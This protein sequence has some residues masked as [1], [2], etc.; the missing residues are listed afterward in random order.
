MKNS[1]LLK[2]RCSELLQFM[3][4]TC[5]PICNDHRNLLTTFLRSQLILSFDVTKQSCV[6]SR[7]VKLLILPN[8]SLRHLYIQRCVHILEQT[9]LFGC[10]LKIKFRFFNDIL[11]LCIV[12]EAWGYPLRLRILLCHVLSRDQV[13]IVAKS[14]E[15]ARRHFAG[16]KFSFLSISSSVSICDILPEYVLTEQDRYLS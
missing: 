2:N 15:H 8:R 12:P 13:R 3:R 4:K 16:K 1:L 6:M 11:V 5:N 9:F 10:P 14:F 7:T